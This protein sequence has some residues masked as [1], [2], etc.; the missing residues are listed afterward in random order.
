MKN[1]LPLIL[2]LLSGY[3]DCDSTVVFNEVMYHPSASQTD[4][5]WVEFYNQMAVNMD[6]SGWS[7]SGGI[8]YTFPE[9]TVVLGGGYLLVAGNPGALDS[10]MQTT[11]TLGPWEG[12]LANEGEEVIL[13][14]NSGREMDTLDYGDSYPWTDGA[15]GTG[16]SLS[17]KLSWIGTKDPSNWIAS[18]ELG[19]TPGLVNFEEGAGKTEIACAIP[20]DAEWR[21][22]DS[23]QA[24]TGDWKATSYDDS[25]WKT[26]KALFTAGTVG[27]VLGPGY[28]G[29]NPNDGIVDLTNSS[30]EEGALNAWPG[31]GPVEGWTGTGSVGNSD[32]SG[33]IA[34]GLII[35]DGE[36]IGFIKGV[37]TL[38]QVVSGLVVGQKYTAR[39]RVNERGYVSTAVARPSVSL[40]GTVVV[41]ERDDVCTNRYRLVV[42]DSAFTAT[43]TTAELVL[44]NN[45]AVATYGDNTVLFDDIVVANA[46]P[47]VVDGSFE[48]PDIDG[49][50]YGPSGSAWNC[51]VGSL[52]L[53]DNG[54]G[55]GNPAF[56]GTQA[57][58]LQTVET[59]YQDI[60]GFEIGKVYVLHWA[61]CDR[62]GLGGNDI[63]I[64]LGST[65]VSPLHTVTSGW[66]RK[67]SAPFMALATSYRLTIQSLN[68]AGGDQSTFIDEVY[69]AQSASAPPRNT[70]VQAGDYATYYRKEFTFDGDPS[71]TNL[72]LDSVVASGA[73][74]YLN[75]QELRRVNMPSG[76]LEHTT[77]ASTDVSSTSFTGLVSFSDTP[78]V[79]GTNVLAVEVHP[80]LE[81]GGN[82]LYGSELQTVE[83]PANFIESKIPTLHFSEVEGTSAAS[84]WVEIENLS[85]S[86][87]NLEGYQVG[88][89]TSTAH[90]YVF[91]ATSLQAGDRLVL[92]EDQLGFHPS[93]DD[94]LF[95][96]DSRQQYVDSV[97]VK[98]DPRARCAEWEQRWLHPSQTTPG[99]RNLF[100]LNDSVVINEIMY[101]PRPQFAV[102]PVSHSRTLL[103]MDAVWKYDQSNTPFGPEWYSTDYNDSAWSSGKGLFYVET[104]TLP[105]TKNTPLTLGPVTFYFRTEFTYTPDAQETSLVLSHIVDDGAVFYL[106]G[107]ELFRFN[108]DE[109]PTPITHSSVATWVDN[110]TL[111]NVPLDFDDL[112]EGTNVLAVEVHQSSAGS[113][114]VAFGAQLISQWVEGG[115]PYTDTAQSWVE[116]YNRGTQAVNLAGWSF[117]QGIDYTFG[118]GVSLAAGGYLVVAED[119]TSLKEEF[120]TATILGPFDGKLSGD[121]ELLSLVDAMG[122]VADEVKFDDEGRWP[123][124]P[125]GGGH[126]L[127]LRDPDASNDKP[128]AWAASIE[129]QNASWKTY[130]YRGT[131]QTPAGTSFPTTWHE[132]VMGLLADGEILI[133]DIS[134]IKDPDGS[135]TELMQNGSF[136]DALNH[137]RIIGNHYGTIEAD[138]DNRSNQ[139]LHLKATGATEHMHNHAES[140]F[141]N[142]TAIVVGSVYE[143]SYRARWLAGCSQLNTRLYF[144]YLPKT[145][146]IDTPEGLGG[147]PGQANSVLVENAGP[148]YEGLGHSPVIPEANTSVQ[149]TIKAADPDGIAEMKVWWREDGGTWEETAMTSTDGSLYSGYI[150][151]QAASTVMQFYIEGIDSLGASSYYPAEGP[152]SRAMITTKDGRTNT[153]LRH[154]IRMLMFDA[155]ATNLHAYT[156]AMSNEHQPCTVIYDEREVFYN[157]GVRLKGSG[158]GR[159]GSRLGFIIYFTPDHLFRG[160]HH[161]VALDRNG[162][163]WTVGASQHELVYKQILNHAGGVPGTYDDVVDVISA[164]GNEDTTAQLLMSRAN[165]LYFDSTY[166]SGSDGFLHEFELIYYSTQTSDGN[167]E[168]LKLPPGFFSSGFP[169]IGVE[170]N[171]MGNDKESYRW[172]YLIKNH[173]DHDYFDHIMQMAKAFSLSG[174]SLQEA[175]EEVIDIPE[176]MRAFSSIV[177][178]GIADIY[179]NGLQHNIQFFERPDTNKIVAMSWDTDHTFYMGS[180]SSIYG[181]GSNV[182]NLITIAE[183]KRLYLGHMLHLLKTSFNPTYTAPWISHF[184]SKTGLSF[185]STITTYIQERYNY[186]LSQMPTEV[187]FAITTNSGKDFSVSTSQAL[188]TGSGWINVREIRIEGRSGTLTLEWP[189]LTTWR[190]WITLAPGI[191]PI[192]LTAYGYQGE[193]LGTTSINITNTNSGNPLVDNLRLTELMYDPALGSDYEFIEMRN[194]ST[195]ETLNLGGATFSNGITYTFPA[196]TSLAP[197]GYLLL[198]KTSDTAN[199]LAQYGLSGDIQILGG[200]SGKLANEGERVTLETFSGGTVIFDFEYGDGRGWPLAAG[201]AGHS[202]VP[203]A[204]V[205]DNQPY[206]ALY[207]GGNWRASAYINGSPGGEDPTPPDAI[208]FNEIKSNTTFSD[209]AY[210]GY[211]S[212]DWIELYN[213]GDSARDLTGWYLSDSVDNLRKWSI[214]SGT[215]GSLGTISFDEI[216]GFHN[217][218]TAGFGLSSAGERL[219]LAYLPGTPEDRVAA[220]IDFKGQQE[221]E[222][223]GCYPDGNRFDFSLPPSRDSANGAPEAHPV[224]SEIMYCPLVNTANPDDNTAEEF[225]EIYNPA[226]GEIPLWNVYGVWRLDGGVTFEFPSNVTL[227]AGKSLIIV[228]FDPTDTDKLTSF[229][230][231]YGIAATDSILGPYQGVLS[232]RGERLALEMPL[233]DPDGTDPSWKII[234][235]VM[236]FNQSPWDSS[237]KGT[238]LSLQRT[239]VTGSG[240]AP[241]C[242]NTGIPSPDVEAPDDPTPTPTCTP[243]WSEPVTPTPTRTITPTPTE[244][245]EGASVVHEWSLYR[246]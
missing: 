101:H 103:S 80:S 131:A 174:T 193:V 166:P 4:V 138:P 185:N 40:G 191:N 213:A 56:E 119:V 34:N 149:V 140:T 148:T 235:E 123:S 194:T 144:N 142:N 26:G 135:R 222:S 216:T 44:R 197:N 74:F 139:V 214:P 182:S 1:L 188:L 190:S 201:G 61:E 82:V 246:P 64:S 29:S 105:A 6:L 63:K 17:K 7:L 112:V 211:T 95:L 242:W 98:A 155:D 65:V 178:G 200:F 107:E 37:G 5:E 150:P 180:T 233:S 113:G 130:T 78:L 75:G 42:G 104:S 238:G 81:G 217:P 68:T 102:D 57:L 58:V 244:T 23:S 154:S 220:C 189:F 137:W 147:T 24:P 234:D 27:L 48:Y 62:S 118:D 205:N 50:V 28:P 120:P 236:Y 176:W 85:N 230:S 59:I 163:P 91:P 8:E 53:S 10:L 108:M 161:E 15:D 41:S 38:T 198:V 179:H 195:T 79:F 177:L 156:N 73:V 228:G 19:G 12:N 20:V 31:I 21:Y 218:V 36:R 212:N 115:G 2:L 33:P 30:F 133:D 52:I 3:G 158:F 110:G 199:F 229:C 90:Q 223:T 22:W 157:V 240:N 106:N 132:L 54:S 93:E 159:V 69:L 209:P 160:V 116:L 202:L 18:L 126:S 43:S 77:P 152:D 146:L 70:A 175:A 215:I 141:V 169:V 225:I 86:M 164:S 121:G 171:D 83:S 245:P 153:S 51:S 66:V 45:A 60:S 241:E 227:G 117:G 243:T 237:A 96:A 72:L 207:Y 124:Y 210:P 114:D 239:S 46:A 232:N 16:Y 39:Y 67:T 111:V 128:E 122:N 187:A 94:V 9:G 97:R 89:N 71:Q 204:S 47:P 136:E 143:I 162:G 32:I 181:S 203:L 151:G 192:V 129:K 221:D 49:Y 172:Y 196:N 165:D 168:S 92:R 208:V 88:D 145:T 35:P 186:A 134:V 226:T 14:D 206:G 183:N 231:A 170:L 55:F 99:S 13:S 109:A 100:N 219:Y 25:S 224:I 11:G 76:T 173:R 167:V 125:D 127:E 84:F 87:V 184:G